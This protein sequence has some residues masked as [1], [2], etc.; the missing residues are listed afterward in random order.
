MKPPMKRALKLVIGA[1]AIAGAAAPAAASGDYS[2]T[3][4]WSL[5]PGAEASCGNSA[6]LNPDNDTRTNLFFL[7]RNASGILAKPLGYP[8]PEWSTRSFGHSFFNWQSLV[9]TYAQV[10]SQV[11][12]YGSRCDSLVSGADAFAAALAASNGL[13]ATERDVLITARGRL[14]ASCPDFAE[15]PSNAAAVPWPTALQSAPGKA[16][17][18]YLQAAEA[19]YGGSW[20]AARQGFDQLQAVREPWVAETASYMLIRVDLNAAQDKAFDEY[21]DF[22]GATNT[23]ATAVARAQTAIAAYLKRYPSG[24][25]A[26]SARGLT[27]RAL[28]LSGDQAALSQE[29]ERLLAAR[30]ADAGS[31]AVLIQEI[32]NKLLFEDGAAQAIQTPRLLAAFDLL[33]M[34]QSNEPGSAPMT[35]AQVAAQKGRFAGQPQLHAYLTAA[36]AFYVDRDYRRALALVPASDAADLT[37]LAFSQQMLRG[38]ALA[39]LRDPQE[40]PQ[41]LSLITRAKAPYQ[42]EL[43]EV[44]L[45]LAW[46]R[47]GNIDQVFASGSPV[48]DATI[49]EILLSRIASP[50]LLRKVA[51]DAALT[52]RMR[53]VAVF[54]L[55][56]KDL[57]TGRFADFRADR[58]LIGAAVSSEGYLD[59]YPFNEIIPVGLFRDDKRATDF[60]CPGLFRTADMLASNP[61]DAH[62]Q[63]CLGDFW[64][65]NG[66]DH[67]S[68][69]DP[70]AD[71]DTLG[72]G[73]GYFP[74]QMMTRAAIYSAVLANPRAAADDKAY[75]L[76][77]SVYCYAP[78][79]N[80]DCGGED[81][82]PDQRRA[83]FQQ[84]KRTYPQSRWARKL[85]VYW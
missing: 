52:Q 54:A 12:S 61:A 40:K 18:G 80:N 25:Y 50:T 9:R 72:A 66:F 5:T 56:H 37:P 20:D 48:Q 31:T 7:Q 16:F 39:A 70:V 13:P 63:L 41:W 68:G 45:A 64:R 15:E 24:R 29:Y 69:T 53:D 6:V 60:A 75:A 11:S 65:L 74:G 84:L 47:E 21:G 27:R 30:T 81:V 4:S 23:D 35:A 59:E 22:M 33:Q 76:Y 1:A 55:L 3:Q 83:W 44:G 71:A 85:T 77:R 42:R 62:A 17:L 67:F 8:Q 38:M 28:W 43:A 78:A 73:P 36:Q 46:Q 34:R 49:R 26:D 14:G 79:G 82:S 58:A 32:D 19:F 51:A 57:A 2:C 10:Q